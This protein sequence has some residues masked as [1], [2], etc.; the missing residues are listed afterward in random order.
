MIVGN[1]SYGSVPD[2]VKVS[3]FVM[4]NERDVPGVETGA[5]KVIVFAAVKV[6]E[7]PVKLNVAPIAIFVP[8]IVIDLFDTTPYDGMVEI[9]GGELDVLVY[10][11]VNVSEFVTVNVN[12]VPAVTLVGVKVMISAALLILSWEITIDELLVRVAPTKLLPVT[13]HCVFATNPNAPVTELITGG[14]SDKIV[15]DAGVGLF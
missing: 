11:V 10:V 6:K 8:V 5:L 13:V 1:G 3:G 15:I 9:T 12:A 4:V 7:L 2:V 14:E